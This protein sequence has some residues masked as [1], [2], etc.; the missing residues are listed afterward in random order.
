MTS[1][2][3]PTCTSTPFT[4]SIVL[5]TLHLMI[6]AVQV[7]TVPFHLCRHLVLMLQFKSAV[8]SEQAPYARRIRAALIACL[9]FSASWHHV[10]GRRLS[11]ELGLPGALILQLNAALVTQQLL[12]YT[13]HLLQSPNLLWRVQLECVM[14]DP[15]QH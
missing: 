2:K 14:K 12:Q 1:L 15:R 7:N 5:E 3:T 13:T 10:I 6:R 11:S 4:C 8:I 9:G